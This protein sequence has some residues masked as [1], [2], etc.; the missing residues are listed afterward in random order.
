MQKPSELNEV[1]E[2]KRDMEASPFSHLLSAL[3]QR[4]PGAFAAALVDEL[5]ETVDYFGKFDP[6]ELKV[7]AA[8]WQIVLSRA[9][10]STI[11]SPRSVSISAGARSYIVVAFDT[12][13]AAVVLL[14]RRSSVFPISRA[15][16]AFEQALCK[17]AGWEMRPIAEPWF[18]VAVLCDETDRPRRVLD[19]AHEVEIEVLGSVHGLSRRERGFRVR[20]RA[21]GELTLVRETSGFW[22]ADTR[23]GTHSQRPPSRPPRKR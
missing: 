17:E 12:G 7:T 1:E 2:W 11:G 10:I 3:I 21:G 23:V 19:G 8:H 14:S 20:S 13:Y 6:F 18:G 15:F 4:V 22:Y 9:A 5:G 16:A